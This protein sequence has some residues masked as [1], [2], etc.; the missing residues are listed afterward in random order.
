MEELESLVEQARSGDLR[1]FGEVVLRFQDMACACAYAALGDFHLAEDVA[2][3][4]FVEAYRQL[5]S[6][7][8]AAAFPG[9]FRRIVVKHIDRVTRRKRLR[10]APLEAA[11]AAQAPTDVSPAQSAERHELHEHVLRAVRALPEHQRLV[12]ALFYIDGYSQKEI[13]TFLEVPVTTVKKRLHDARK[14][15]KERMLAMVDGTLKAAAPDERFSRR[16]IAEL[17]AR[18]RLLDF[19]GHPVREVL[20]AM[21][22][23]MPG[24][25]VVDG[26]EVVDKSVAALPPDEAGRAYHVDETQVLRTDTTVTLLMA[27]LGRQPPVRLLTAGRVFRPDGPEGAQRQKVFHQMDAL[28]IE[29]GVDVDTMKTTLGRVLEAAL[30][31]VDIAW[32][33]HEYPRFENGFEAVLEGSGGRLGVAGSGMFTAKTLQQGGYDPREVSGFAFGLGI[34]RLAMVKLGIDDIRELWQPPYVPA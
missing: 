3:E 9:W 18:P 10:T 7:R 33:P 19:E 24:Y 13:A 14:K 11:S 25:E 27:M 2:Q 12:T 28:C 1:A 17:R 6:L 30:G 4:A 23:A 16:I 20:D 21:V 32:E 22:A 26:Q 34:E 29:P 15:L 31:P 8:E 5:P